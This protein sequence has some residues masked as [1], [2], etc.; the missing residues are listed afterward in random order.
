[1]KKL[2]PFL[3][4]LVGA[5]AAFGQQVNFNNSPLSNPPPRLVYMPDNTTP[6]VGSDTTLPATF[7]AQL[8]YGAAGASESSLQPITA[9]GPA[10]FR[11]GTTGPG[12]WLGGFRTL[13]GFAIGDTVTLQVRA[14]D[15][16]GTAL[17]YDAARAQGRLFGAGGTFTYTI[18]AAG[19]APTA[20]YIEGFRSFALVPEPSVIGLGLIGI[21]A[22]FM[23]RRRK[24]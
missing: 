20:Y 8:Y 1:M 22:L 7:V 11:P 19:Q 21:G 18:P 17:T 2:I 15:A 24:A 3:L 13:T 23:L 16:A 12:L 6:V 9:I 14:W 4:V 10:R 5:T